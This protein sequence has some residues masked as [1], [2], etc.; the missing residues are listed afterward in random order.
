M[1]DIEAECR[2]NG[3]L[4][5]VKQLK[6]EE[7]KPD[8]HTID[9]DG[10]IW[11]ALA[12]TNLVCCYNPDTGMHQALPPPCFCSP[13]PVSSMHLCCHKSSCNKRVHQAVPFPS[14]CPFLCLPIPVCH[15]CSTLC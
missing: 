8:G 12:S 1:C 13:L 9:A 11:E 7:G 2:E 10:N 14:L 3:K 4:K 6:I 5:Q 15:S